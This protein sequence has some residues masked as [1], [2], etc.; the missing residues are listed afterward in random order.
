[1]SHSLLFKM[2]S[3]ESGGLPLSG[4]YRGMGGPNSV[5]LSAP[6]F[7]FDRPATLPHSK[8]LLDDLGREN[9]MRKSRIS[10]I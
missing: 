10:K 6:G 7:A 5:P 2:V 9:I 4:D 1:M 3:T 8:C